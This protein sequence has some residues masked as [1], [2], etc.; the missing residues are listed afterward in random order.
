MKMK[1]KEV[2]FGLNQLDELT[3]LLFKEIENQNIVVFKGALGA[4]KTSLIKNI[5]NFLGVNDE[6]SSPTFA[7]VNEYRTSQEQPVFHFDCYRL[8][9][10]E[11]ALDLGIEEYLDS[12]HLC[13]IEWPEQIENL[14]P[15]K[16][17]EVS[18]VPQGE[19]RKY[20]LK[21]IN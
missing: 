1:I 13:L 4:G 20:T 21:I 12:D 10:E 17:V 9:T 3:K 19:K 2:I 11:E 14:L 7:I 16:L 15:E 8:K 6:V 5:C 18:I